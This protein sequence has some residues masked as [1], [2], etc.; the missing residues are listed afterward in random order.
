[1]RFPGLRNLGMTKIKILAPITPENVEVKR[2][3]QAENPGIKF[4][5]IK[6]SL[7]SAR[8]GFKRE[9]I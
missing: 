9:K 4:R 1:M 5:A 8:N 2:V 3:K 7:A 6:R